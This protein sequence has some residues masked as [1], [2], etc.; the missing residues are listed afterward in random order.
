MAQTNR[1]T[2]LQG[3]RAAK[4]SMR[5]EA[6]KPI[7]DYWRD[8]GP[9]AIALLQWCLASFAAVEAGRACLVPEYGPHPEP[10]DGKRRVLAES[11]RIAARLAAERA[12]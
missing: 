4:P 5:L 1:L 10:S 12:G 8:P 11:D 6:R 3:Q 7:G 9:A 2:A